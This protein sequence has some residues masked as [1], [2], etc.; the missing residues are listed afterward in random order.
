MVRFEEVNVKTLRGRLKIEATPGG[1]IYIS[2]TI[3][4][5]QRIADNIDKKAQGTI[6]APSVIQTQR[7]GGIG[8]NVLKELDNIGGVQK[9]YSVL[10][11]DILIFDKQVFNSVQFKAITP[12]FK[13][14]VVKFAMGAGI[15]AGVAI[16]LGNQFN[17]FNNRRR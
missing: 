13:R 3:G 2:S 4:I 10:Y 7:Q 1:P 17:L 14:R 6:K 8:G 15:A 11:H 16:L 5:N 12:F 9:N